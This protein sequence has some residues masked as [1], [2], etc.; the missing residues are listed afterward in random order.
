MDLEGRLFA[1]AAHTGKTDLANQVN[2]VRLGTDHD[3]YNS[4][5]LLMNLE[6]C[7]REISTDHIFRFVAEHERSC[8]CRIKIFSTP[9]TAVGFYRWTMP[10][11]IM[12]PGITTPTG[13]PAEASTT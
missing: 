8:C 12:T 4:G 5:V 9:F 6:A 11:G 10:S 3:Y 13:L 7:R 2:R 1:A